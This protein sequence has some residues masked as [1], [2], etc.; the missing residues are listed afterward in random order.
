MGPHMEQKW[1]V[2]A[3]SAGKVSSWKSMARAGSRPRANW[4]LQRNSKRAFEMAL[5]RSWAAG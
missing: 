3:P 4:S 1:A 2:L 5:S